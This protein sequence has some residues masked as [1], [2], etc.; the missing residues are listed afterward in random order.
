MKEQLDELQKEFDKVSKWDREIL[1]A[2]LDKAIK[3]NPKYL[4]ADS[5]EKAKV[6]REL[7]N[8]KAFVDSVKRETERIQVGFV[9]IEPQTG[10]IK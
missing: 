7:L 3:Q 10:Y 9:A 4:E 8:D 5:A 2:V 6:Y 1:N